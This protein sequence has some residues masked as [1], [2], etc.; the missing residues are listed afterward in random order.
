MAKSRYLATGRRLCIIVV[1]EKMNFKD[2]M[3]VNPVFVVTLVG[4]LGLKDILWEWIK[5]CWS[6]NDEKDND[7]KKLEELSEKVDKIIEKLE[8][9]DAN[10]RK[11]MLNDLSIFETDLAEMQNRA[12]IKGKVSRTCMPRYM[13]DYDLYMKLAEETEGYDAS[14][15]VKMNHQRILKLVADGHIADNLEEWYK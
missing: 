13:K 8:A 7:H 6:K 10:D 2:F 1:E 9:M 4:A 12:I 3:E 14:E 11:G 15:E 5:R